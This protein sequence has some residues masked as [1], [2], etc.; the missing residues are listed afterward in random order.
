MS[1]R[2]FLVALSLVV[3]AL[4]FFPTSCS[5]GGGF[6]DD[7]PESD[8][9]VLP[10]GSGGAD[11]MRNMD[12]AQPPSEPWQLAAGLHGGSVNSIAISSQ[13]PAHMWIGTNGNGV[14]RSIDGGRSWSQSGKALAGMDAT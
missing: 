6:M 3:A 1:T 5:S 12:L 2:R 8:G 13:N 11:G 14:F 4:I 10:D 9:G 7:P